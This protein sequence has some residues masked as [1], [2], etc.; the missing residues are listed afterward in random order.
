MG[1]ISG[2]LFEFESCS[3]LVFVLKFWIFFFQCFIKICLE[4]LIVWWFIEFVVGL[5]VFN[6]LVVG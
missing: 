4:V 1:Y 5:E 6:F 3:W 2:L